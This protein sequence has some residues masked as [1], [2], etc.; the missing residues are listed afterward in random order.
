M[1]RTTHGDIE[2]TIIT[3]NPQ[4]CLIRNLVDIVSKGEII[5]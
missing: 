5:Y 2:A 1:T 3:G 4:R